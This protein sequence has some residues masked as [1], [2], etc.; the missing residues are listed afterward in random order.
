MYRKKPELTAGGLNNL[1]Y[2]GNERH[3][4]FL[5]AFKLFKF[6]DFNKWVQRE[7]CLRPFLLSSAGCCR[8]PHMRRARLMNP[9]RRCHPSGGIVLYGTVCVFIRLPSRRSLQP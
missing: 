9:P 4:F 6:T 3:N 5:P 8:S 2:G 7:R 1:S